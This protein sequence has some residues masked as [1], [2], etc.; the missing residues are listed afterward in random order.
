[1]GTFLATALFAVPLIASLSANL[2][3]GRSLSPWSGFSFAPL[4]PVLVFS[5]SHFFARVKRFLPFA[6]RSAALE[7]NS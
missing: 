5:I 6:N 7:V 2:S 4:R 3:A 1:M